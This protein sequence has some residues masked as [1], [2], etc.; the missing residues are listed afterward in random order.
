MANDDGWSALAFLKAQKQLPRLER[1][2]APIS[3]SFGAP[4]SQKH[5]ST[6]ASAWGKGARQWSRTPAAPP[7]DANF[8]D[9]M[10][11]ELRTLVGASYDVF[12]RANRLDD[13]KKKTDGE[14]TPFEVVKASREYREALK[15]C[16]FAIEDRV[17]LQQRKKTPNGSSAA[18][19]ED[20]DEEFVDLLKVSLAIWHLCELLF[21][22]RRPRDDKWIAYDLAQWLQEHFA[23]AL[24]EQLDAASATLRTASQPE[25]DPAFWTTVHSL[26]MAGCGSSAWNLLSV[27]S[28]YK[29]L[30]GRDAASLT[31]SS[32]LSS[33]Q[34]IQRLLL[35]MPGKSGQAMLHPDGSRQQEAVE[36]TNWHDA[37]QYLMNTDSYIKS[38]PGLSKLLRIMVAD[39]DVLVRHATTW[40]E[41]MMARLFLDEPKRV[42]HRFEFLMANCFRTYNADSNS[43]GNFDCIIMA[44]LEYDV[45]SA[46]QDI[47]A[48]GFT[49]MATHLS[50]LLTK[51][52]AISDDVLEQIDVSLQEYF[53]LHYAMDIGASSGMWQFAVGYY[54]RCPHLGLIAARSAL[55]REPVPTDDKANRLLAYCQSTRGLA[56]LQRKIAYRR[57]MVCK[58]K[59]YGAA[60]MWLLRGNHLDEIDAICDL[61]LRKCEETKSL[62]PL[63]EAVEFLEMHPEMAR[64]PKL[65]WLIRYRELYLV[66]DDSE[67]LEQQQQQER[68]DEERAEL[69]TKRRF[70]LN[71]AAKRIHL[72]VSSPA[73]PRQLRAVLLREAEK[74]LVAQ[75]TV[76]SSQYLH[77][78]MAYLHQLDRSFDRQDFYRST[79]NKQLKERVEKLLARNLSEAILAEAA[80]GAL[81]ATGRGA[82]AVVGAASS[83]IPLLAAS[84]FMGN[85]D[86]SFV[87]MEE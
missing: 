80:T 38:S 22:Q 64:T 87:P 78:L 34:S 14:L 70:V 82:S 10:P 47:N 74:L 15:T 28:S 36:W 56:Q 33:F 63:N 24:M 59:S 77:S 75:P 3:S 9:E 73:A 46:L 11:R 72:L 53:Y 45:Q 60:L 6:A 81:A 26:V 13:E 23:S 8:S 76:Y 69:E 52:N 54:E 57:A 18:R 84:A 51:S 83:S 7:A 40:Y 17:E 20:D 67:S 16:I 49:W 25:Q 30:F 43:M 79:A 61:V 62:S 39:E 50:D 1:P 85:G 42:A 68:G 2:A 5:K 48:L 31:S 37:C 21:L 41:L 65:G 27:H 71:E 66:V 86:R 19:E 55:E 29:A 44:I 4:L 12:M 35:C 58:Q 32:T